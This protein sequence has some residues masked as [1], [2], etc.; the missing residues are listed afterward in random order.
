MPDIRPPFFTN[1]LMA[2]KPLKLPLLLPSQD[3]LGFLGLEG[4]R[5]NSAAALFVIS[6]ASRLTTLHR[7]KGQRG[8]T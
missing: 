3:F 4:L 5:S 7:Q 8:A 6:T 2:D 1:E